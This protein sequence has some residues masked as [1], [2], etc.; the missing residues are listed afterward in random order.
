VLQIYSFEDDMQSLLFGL[1][2]EILAEISSSLANQL[3]LPAGPKS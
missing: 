3:L 2:R 1:T